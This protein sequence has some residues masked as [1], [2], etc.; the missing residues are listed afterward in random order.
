MF[1]VANFILAVT[2]ILDMILT[3]YFWVV[4]ARALLS[5]VNP[6]PYNPIVSFLYRITEPLLA[7]VRRILPPMGG[8]DLSPM[9][10]MVAIFFVKQFVLSSLYDVAYRLKMPGV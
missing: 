8:I 5:W 10:L 2:R 1:I 6:D 7:R 9:L 3:L 4:I